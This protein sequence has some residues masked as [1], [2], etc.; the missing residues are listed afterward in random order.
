MHKPRYRRGRS[1]P[2]LDSDQATF[3]VC[4]TIIALCLGVL[5]FAT[6][7]LLWSQA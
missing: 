3:L 2:L 5:A 4:G 6:P 7:Y 1:A